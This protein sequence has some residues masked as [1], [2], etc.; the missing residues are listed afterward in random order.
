MKLSL[1]V[2]YSCCMLVAKKNSKTKND[3][4]YFSAKGTRSGILCYIFSACGICSGII[5]V[6][7]ARGTR[8]GVIVLYFPRVEHALAL[9][10][11]IFLRVGHAL[12]LLCYIF[13]TWNAL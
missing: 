3:V 10:F 4:L 13:R 12:T 1:S 7:Y 8:S 2:L 11:Y 9:F 5:V 6:F